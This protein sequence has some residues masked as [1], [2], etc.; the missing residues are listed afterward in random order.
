MTEAEKKA[1]EL[2]EKLKQEITN[3]APLDAQRNSDPNAI[4]EL[5]K[6]AKQCALIACEEIL[7]VIEDNCLDYD[8]NFWQ[9]V[10]T[11]IQAL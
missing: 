1:K 11:A 6:A 10:K 3:H 8:D 2:V 5:H 4:L 9:E 7:A